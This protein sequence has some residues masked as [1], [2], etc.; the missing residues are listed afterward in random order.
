VD[1]I[2]YSG[3][4]YL[5]KQ[6]AV[7]LIGETKA[8]KS[9]LVSA[10]V[11]DVGHD[12]VAFKRSGFEN[13]VSKLTLKTLAKLEDA[14]EFRL[15]KSASF[16]ETLWNEGVTLGQIEKGTA[17]LVYT[18]CI[19]HSSRSLIILD[20]PTTFLDISERD[21]L[22]IAIRNR[23][24]EKMMLVIDHD[25]HF[26]LSV[27][28][29]F[30]LI[31]RLRKGKSKISYPFKPEMLLSLI[32]NRNDHSIGTT[33][34]TKLC[35]LIRLH[36]TSFDLSILPKPYIPRTVSRSIAPREIVGCIGPRRSGKTGFL[37]AVKDS[38]QKESDFDVGFKRTFCCSIPSI[39]LRDY[40]S[41]Y[42][43]HSWSC[44]AVYNF[45]PSDLESYLEADV[46]SVPG[47]YFQAVLLASLLLGGSNFLLIDNPSLFLDYMQ[48]IWF[49]EA[50]KRE[51]TDHNK[52][53]IVVDSN[54]YL[55][56]TVCDRVFSFRRK[57]GITAVQEV[58]D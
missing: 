39:S 36:T 34:R 56:E 48:I 14:D 55:L 40:I 5:S 12:N 53:C 44:L 19:L 3:D 41:N 22:A 49:A 24:K 30:Q 8:G 20:E 17:N 18:L 13:Y 7:G 52:I 38:A 15:R 4:L 2:I 26:L 28:N 31:T 54:R 46:R 10:L 58:L 9:T 33:K 42:L 47:T 43:G 1:N 16:V 32:K 35:S 37:Q 11:C 51:V 27:L 57:N 25:L 29:D 6:T 45:V 50:L 23:Q 21:I